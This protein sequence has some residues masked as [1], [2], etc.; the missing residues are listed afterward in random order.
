MTHVLSEECDY[1]VKASCLCV[2][3]VIYVRPYVTLVQLT[4]QFKCCSVNYTSRDAPRI[5]TLPDNTSSKY[6]CANGLCGMY[7]FLIYF[8]EV[9]NSLVIQIILRRQLLD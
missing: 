1:G 2:S 7:I 5:Q 6:R 4:V 3:D 9:F 8:N